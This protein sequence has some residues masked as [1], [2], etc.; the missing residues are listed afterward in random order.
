MSQLR[1]AQRTDE[2][3]TWASVSRSFVADDLASE[4]ADT[5]PDEGFSWHAQRQLLDAL[6]KTQSPEARRH[7]VRTRALIER[8]AD[9]LH[10]REALAQAWQQVGED[11]LSSEYRAAL[12]ACAG[13]DLT[14]CQMQS[15]FWRY[16]PGSRFDPH[17]DKPH[18]IVTHLLYFN[19]GWQDEWGGDLRLLNSDQVDDVAAS[20]TPTAGQG[21]VLV[22]SEQAW[23]AVK[24]LHDGHGSRKVL[25]TWFWG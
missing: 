17:V 12:G 16:E 20:V 6:G 4:L 21:I 14:G 8:G 15:H 7:A 18:K 22:R 1:G 2:P 25:Q 13:V 19:P 23:H 10:A 5:F 3:F 9:D 11:L 24:E